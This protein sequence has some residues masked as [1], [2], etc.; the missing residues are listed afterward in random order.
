MQWQRQW[1]APVSPPG[2]VWPAIRNRMPTLAPP[3]DCCGRVL[4]TAG[5]MLAAGPWAVP[6]PAA[7]A[8]PGGVGV[9]RPSSCTCGNLAFG[10]T[11]QVL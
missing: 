9:P 6:V 11:N 7:V 5:Q 10:L 2:V 1:Y 8:G 3:R 4:L